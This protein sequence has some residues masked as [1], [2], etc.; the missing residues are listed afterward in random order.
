MKKLT[1]L[2]ILTILPLWAKAYYI[3]D[4][5][6]Y[7]LNETAKTASVTTGQYSANVFIPE[8]VVYN[9][10]NYAVTSI[11]DQAFYCSYSLKSV[12]IPSS[13]K[14]IGNMA[15][16]DCIKLSSVTISSG[17]TTIGS[18]AFRNCSRLT[19]ITLPNSIKSYYCP[20]NTVFLCPTS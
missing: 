19:S 15:F 5:I 4:G 14:T 8:S 7:N 16:R 10:S 9:G 11:G 13:V 3:I 20:L 18:E 17:I 2:F 6:Y 12:T 1:L